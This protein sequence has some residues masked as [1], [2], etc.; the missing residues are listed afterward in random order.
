MT[1]DAGGVLWLVINVLFVLTLGGALVYGTLMW[2]KYKKHPTQTVERDRATWEA[3]AS[4]RE[5]F[6]GE[7]ESRS[8]TPT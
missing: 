7:P 3:F 8:K 2:R 5:K 4:G 1:E 6:G